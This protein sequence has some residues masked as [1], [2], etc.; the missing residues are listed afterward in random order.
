MLV[1]AYLMSTDNNLIQISLKNIDPMDPSA[2]KDKLEIR[3]ILTKNEEGSFYFGQKYI[4]VL[5]GK[6]FTRIDK[7]SNGK[8]VLDFPILKSYP[9]TMIGTDTHI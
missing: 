3:V 4:Y 5:A 2:S 6:Q 1:F 8:K 9:K 7:V